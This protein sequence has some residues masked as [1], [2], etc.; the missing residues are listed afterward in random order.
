MFAVFCVTEIGKHHNF[1]CGQLY[2]ILLLAATQVH[3]D[4]LRESSRL[5][6]IL[7]VRIIFSW[8]RLIELCCFS[9]YFPSVEIIQGL[10]EGKGV[11]AKTSIPK[12][13]FV[14]NYGGK[15]LTKQEGKSYMDRKQDYV[16]FVRV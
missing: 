3:F 10:P 13:S 2:I 6:K 14:C 8:P 15:L 16:L 12:F 7:E 1:S 5:Q 9:N 4:T 11:Q